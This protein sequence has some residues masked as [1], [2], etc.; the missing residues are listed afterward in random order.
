VGG[1]RGFVINAIDTGL[2]QGFDV[3]FCRGE[4]VFFAAV[5][6][7]DEFGFL[8]ESRQIRDVREANAAAAEHAN[9]GER[10]EVRESDY[11]GLH[12]AHREASHGAM[13]LIGEGAEICVDVGNE[14]INKDMLESG[15]VEVRTWAWSWFGRVV[16]SGGAASATSEWIPAEFHGDNKR[17]GFSFGEEVVHDPAGV[18]LA[19]PA[20]FVFTGAVLQIEHGIT[21]ATALVVIGRRVNERVPVGVG[22]FGEIPELAK[23]AMRHIFERIKI[24][25]FGRD[26][27]SAA[28]PSRAVEKVAV[29]IRNFGSIDIN[30][31]VVKTFVQWPGVAGPGTVVAF[32]ELAAVP[33]TYANGLSFGRDDAEFDPTFGVNLR[34]LFAP[35]IGGGGSPVIGGFVSLRA[36]ELEC[37]NCDGEDKYGF[38]IHGI[39]LILQGCDS[40]ADGMAQ[41]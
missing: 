23:L 18:S 34:I 33:E 10:V 16:G 15:E 21:I 30:R 14:I 24:L 4:A 8:F 17:P 25:I 19:S 7:K 37:K 12:A 28:P 9:V 3:G 38:R 35:L 32:C 11:A 1:S 13:R 5:T 39:Y 31:I 41:E 27:D 26:F 2:F 6:D 22:G 36:S 20:G 40:V 29:R